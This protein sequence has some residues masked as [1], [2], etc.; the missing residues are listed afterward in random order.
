MIP[1]CNATMVSKLVP[2]HTHECSGKH[3]SGD[4]MCRHPECRRYFWENETTDAAQ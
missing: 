1:G 2:G 4:H 3:D